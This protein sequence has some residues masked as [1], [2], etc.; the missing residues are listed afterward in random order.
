MVKLQFISAAILAVCGVSNA[1]KP[2][3]DIIRL[4]QKSAGATDQMRI[5]TKPRAG[6]N[7]A[8]DT[9]SVWVMGSACEESSA[10]D[11][12]FDPVDHESKCCHQ[13]ALHGFTMWP[14]K[15]NY[16]IPEGSNIIAEDVFTADEDCR[17]RYTGSDKANVALTPGETYNVYMTQGYTPH[18][19]FMN[20]LVEF[21]NQDIVAMIWSTTAVKN[22][23]E[24]FALGGASTYSSVRGD[25]YKFRG[26]EP[27]TGE[28]G[29]ELNCRKRP[30]STECQQS[31][32]ITV[33]DGSGFG[34][35]HMTTFDGLRYDVHVHA[36]LI[37]VKSLDTTFEIQGRTEAVE[38]H[39]SRPAVTTG[40]VVNEVGD[41]PKIQISLARDLD[42]DYTE[43]MNG[44]PVQLFADDVAR[45]VS[46]GS[47]STKASVEVSNSRITIQYPETGTVV[48]MQVRSW[49]QTCHFS[50]TYILADC[51][52][53]ERIVGLV[54]SPDG[55]WRNDWMK[56]DGTPLP[57][58]PVLRKGSGFEPTYNYT[59][60]NW[61]VNQVSDS[62]F[63][64]EHDTS[65]E[66][67]DHCDNPYDRA[68]EDAI[69]NALPTIVSHC[70]DDIFCMIDYI[71][72]GEEAADAYLEDPALDIPLQQ[73]ASTDID[74]ILQVPNESP[75]PSCPV[76]KA[77]GWGDPHIVTF[78][79]VAYDVHVKGELT[80]LKSLSTDFTIQAR[81]QIVATHPKGPAVT[82][83]VLVHEDSTLNL[84]VVQVSLSRD[85]NSELA[86][87]IG[88]C[89]VQL[90]VD[91]A[92]KDIT[93]GTGSFDSV[94]QVKNKRIV[95]EYPSTGLRVDM[96][97]KVWRNT[98]H[99]SVTY[100]L[101][102][103][104]C[105]ETLVGVLGLPDGD[106]SNDWHQH[107]GTPE[108]IPRR[109]RGQEA[110]DYS[111]RWCLNDAASHF[112]Y[113]PD[114]NHGSFDNCTPDAFDLDIDIIISD[115]APD[116]ITKCTLGTDGVLDE[117]CVLECAF[118]G[119]DA[120]SE[121]IDIISDAAIVDIPPVEGP[122]PNR[123]EIGDGEGEAAENA[124]DGDEDENA[125]AGSNGDPHFKS[126]IGEHFEYHGQCD[127]V[128][129]K[130]PNFANGLGIDVH[131][132]TKLVRH[133][134]FIKN[135]VIRIGNDILEIEG[136]GIEF[137]SKIRYWI[138]YEYEGK[139]DE[140]AGFP[141]T[142]LSQQKTAA[143]KNRIEIDLDSVYPG[144]KIE[145]STFKEFVKVSF[146]NANE[147]S[148]GSSV[149]MLG[150]FKTGKT[151]A[152]DG[153][154]VLDDF[155]EL[156]HE[157]QVLPSDKH[158]FHDIS[159]P[160]FPIR[161]FD[162]EDARGDRRRRLDEFTI[163]EEQ[164]E[165]ACASLKDP[166]DRKDCVYDIL[167]TQDM[168]MAGAY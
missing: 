49:R 79:G 147:E 166:L 135:A 115:A 104:R 155:T 41:N 19:S 74:I 116:V 53:S 164:A 109:R 84:P 54:G 87:M 118:L 110:Y 61:C 12:L 114:M 120:C 162:P 91:G 122:I 14:E 40:I 56:R 97:V 50:V 10:V 83:G 117:G 72:L 139:M 37:F 2:A 27:R 98:C 58:P 142:M 89:P 112:T 105:D 32:E 76:C 60:D 154:T 121:Y 93:L 48:K 51:R 152:R 157:W 44:C 88:E 107:D 38:N 36:E 35:P 163:S 123:G 78:D 108:E 160:Q 140:F 132:R 5:L 25:G 46:A 77:I 126:W 128:L 21:H 165:A 20:N 73:T 6:Y 101:A 71:A 64:Y 167:A 131:I 95:V 1:E 151:L 100:F 8:T 52:P 99:F 62:Y 4:M 134:S 23:D 159:A 15:Q 148:F 94:V 90:F 125:N 124:G 66:F 63:T 16:V 143:T 31:P 141:V 96:Q 59:R 82:T 43:E 127:L 158:F 161:C 9:P 130:D 55:E 144:Q 75:N 80:F 113:E 168:D 156:G 85:Q 39:P 30:D 119:D 3:G 153:V 138:N 137:D 11:F 18:K 70:N 103:C 106:W 133:W 68:L 33:A 65:F 81:T 13:D 149:G 145:L 86:T 150:D 69:N 24:Y 129:I 42:D 34:D 26:L 92:A 22:S 146:E 57:I 7:P 47:G 102:D 45:P 17:K 28:E 111:M 136:S 67:F 29:F